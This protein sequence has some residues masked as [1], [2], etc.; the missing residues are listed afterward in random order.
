MLAPVRYHR[1]LG[2]H[3]VGLPF[4]SIA[5]LSHAL[6]TFAYLQHLLVDGYLVTFVTTPTPI[7]PSAAALVRYLPFIKGAII[8]VP[9]SILQELYSLGPEAVKAA[10]GSLTLAMFGGAPLKK[11]VGDSLVAA[12]LSIGT[13]YGSYVCNDGLKP[14]SSHRH[15]LQNR[16]FF[17]N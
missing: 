5:P 14:M 15:C 3:F 12:G 10:A 1:K 8:V 4:Y 2:Q 6:S 17:C 9:P 16:N 11:D 13:G 7:P